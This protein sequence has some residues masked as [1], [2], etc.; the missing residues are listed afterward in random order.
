M[1][2]AT[3]SLAV[4]NYRRYFAGQVI[5][6]SGNWMQIV[7]E[8]WLVVKLTG[9][10]VSVG[11]TA[12]LQ[13]LPIL[14]L[15]AMAGVL[16]DRYDKRRLLML[17]QALMAV[18]ALALWGLTAAGAIE[19]WMVYVLVLVRGVVLAVDNPTRQ[20]FVMELVGP[21]RIVNAVSLNS[22]IVHTSRI[23]GPMLAGGLIALVGVSLCF[24]V[25]ALSFVAMLVALHGM[26]PRRLQSA[27]PVARERGQVRAGVR[28]VLRRP[29]LRVPLAMMV[30][31]GTLSFNFQVLLPLLARF[32][33]HG[34]AGTYAL[35]TSAMGI[36]SVAGALVAGARGKVSP[37]LLAGSAGVFGVAQL[38]AA[39]APTLALQA[40]VLVPLGAASVTFA[41]GVNSSLQLAAGDALRGRVMA[42][43]S[44]V[45]LGSTPIGA[46]VVGWL[47]EVAGP[48][49]GLLLGG[50]AALATA[51]GGWLALRR[52][53][54]LQAPARTRMIS[55]GRH[56]SPERFS[57]SVRA[58]RELGSVESPHL[59]RGHAIRRPQKEQHNRC[60]PPR[61][62]SSA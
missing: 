14:L 10:G 25:N 58:R 57:S 7:A 9:S 34:T 3:V 18:P 19:I 20:S 38:A 30:V 2:R 28:E 52:A 46:P 53:D 55:I 49:A 23:L 36:G 26:D 42:L 5:S 40:A 59:H 47:A 22:V 51:A 6:I 33:W 31:I 29:E 8:M 39:L 27:P 48:R 44:V 43:Y 21:D 11:L 54:L 61:S 4:P 41:S 16:A 56:G 17:T 62:P 13:F 45:F 32:T 12:A 37:A 60:L 15:G 24:G 1:R 35:L 50:A